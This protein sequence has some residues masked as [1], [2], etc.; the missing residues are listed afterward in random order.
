[1]MHFYA[2]LALKLIAAAVAARL[3]RRRRLVARPV[4]ACRVPREQRVPLL[5]FHFEGTVARP[6]ERHVPAEG[7]G[8]E[9][10]AGGET[11]PGAET[12]RVDPPISSE[13]RDAPGVVGA[14]RRY[15]LLPQQR[16][17]LAA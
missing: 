3:R 12:R 5:R 15:E 8:R 10:A 2:N 16:R 6:P 7:R 9:A 14:E 11:R 17:L 4:E 13:R 1:M